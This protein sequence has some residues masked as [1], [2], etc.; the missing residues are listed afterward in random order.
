MMILTGFLNKIFNKILT[1]FNY[2]W[3]S[4]LN[5]LLKILLAKSRFN[6]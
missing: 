3:Y 4:F 6:F 2:K 5:N 1:N